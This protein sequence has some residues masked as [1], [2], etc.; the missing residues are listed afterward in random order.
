MVGDLRREDEGCN[1][2]S[3][4]DL[5]CFFLIEV[6]GPYISDRLII[7]SER[8]D[9]EIIDEGLGNLFGLFH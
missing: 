3:F 5:M 2:E 8:E 6:A 4:L 9:D 7:G 1:F